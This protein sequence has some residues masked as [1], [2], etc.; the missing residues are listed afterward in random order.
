MKDLVQVFE[1]GQWEIKFYQARDRHVIDLP[2]YSQ[3]F[4]SGDPDAQMNKFGIEL[5]EAGRLKSACSIAA[6]GG[7][8]GIGPATTLINLDGLVICCGNTVFKLSLPGLDLVWQTVCDTATCFEIYNFQQDYI[9]HGE[10]EISRLDKNGNIIWQRGGK[11]IFTTLEGIN[12]FAVYDNYIVA[13]DWRYNQYEFDG[14]GN[15]LEPV[16]PANK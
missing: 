14:E 5:F 1:F 4:I 3:A 2:A 15:L 11:D 6:D 12:D 13:T 10:L 16:G 9:V 7:G 8:T